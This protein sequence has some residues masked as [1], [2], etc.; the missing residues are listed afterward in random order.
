MGPLAGA[1]AEGAAPVTF[2]VPL[3]TI[4]GTL[5]VM[6]RI[7]A[8]IVIAPPFNH[9]GIPA[10]TKALLALAV[11]LAVAPAADTSQ[12]SLEP[13]PLLAAAL[14]QVLLG[15]SLGFLCFLVFAAVQTAGNLIDLFGGFQLAQAFDP[16]LQS[17]ASVF[18]RLYQMVVVV[19]LFAS[20]GHLVMFHGLVSTFDVIGVTDGISLSVTARAVTEGT[21][22]MMVAALQIAGPLI[23]IL[24]LTDVGLGLLTR[25][26]P[27]LQAFSLG[28]PLKIFITLSVAVLAIAMLPAVVDGFADDGARQVLQLANASASADAAGADAGGVAP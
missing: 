5:L 3:Q 12:V 10:R 19:V 28:F 17:G 4:V 26:A 1:F 8:W 22:T 2:D 11:S 9:G 14:S 18:G 24:F 20:D 6:L 23:A 16:Q 15:A 13:G 27:A 21:T 7:T 25:A